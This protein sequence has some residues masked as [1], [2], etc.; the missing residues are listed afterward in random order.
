M[1]IL[2]RMKKAPM[3]A[4]WIVQFETPKTEWNVPWTETPR[5]MDI[6]YDTE[7]GLMDSKFV[8]FGGHWIYLPEVEEQYNEDWTLRTGS[9]DAAHGTRELNFS[10]RKTVAKWL[11]Q[12]NDYIEKHGYNKKWKVGKYLSDENAKKWGLGK[13]R[14]D[15]SDGGAK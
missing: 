3:E 13:Y 12:Q 15:C 7:R 2:S 11:F 14:T 5:H 4:I 9:T 8:R 10:N 1:V 6:V